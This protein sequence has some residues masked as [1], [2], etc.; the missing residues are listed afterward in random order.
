[1]IPIISRVAC[2]SPQIPT[3]II[4]REGVRNGETRRPFIS[5]WIFR[6][7]KNIRRCTAIRGQQLRRLRGEHEQV[8][9]G[10]ARNV[11]MYAYEFSSSRGRPRRRGVQIRRCL[12]TKSPSPLEKHLNWTLRPTV[13]VVLSHPRVLSRPRARENSQNN[14]SLSLSSFSPS[15]SNIFAD[16]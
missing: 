11:F 10:T 14:A 3:R 1:M 9:W 5:M 12:R 2:S 6:V 15:F 8:D 16:I 7:P 13:L 4:I